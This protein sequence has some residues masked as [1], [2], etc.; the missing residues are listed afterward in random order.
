MGSQLLYDRGMLVSADKM[1]L[2]DRLTGCEPYDS[3]DY[4]QSV[5]GRCD[6]RFLLNH[7]SAIRLL[8]SSRPPSV[9]EVGP[10]CEQY[11]SL[12]GDVATSAVSQLWRSSDSE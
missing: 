2:T 9:H 8:E 5:S 11:L 4:T 3:P 10:I 7:T 12:S 1:I 6:N